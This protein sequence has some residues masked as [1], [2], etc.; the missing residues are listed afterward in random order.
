[1]IPE[2][3]YARLFY[4]GAAWLVL[5]VVLVVWT[6]V[7]TISGHNENSRASEQRVAAAKVEHFYLVVAGERSGSEPGP[8]NKL[9]RDLRDLHIPVGSSYVREVQAFRGDSNRYGGVTRDL[10]FDPFEGPNCQE[11]GP[12]DFSVQDTVIAVKGG[13]IDAVIAEIESGIV[14]EDPISAPPLLLWFLWILSFPSFVA[15]TYIH[16]KRREES[17]YRD[18]SHERG[19]IADLKEARAQL[20]A[21]AERD[22]IDILIDGLQSQIDTRVNYAQVKKRD[23]RL[24]ALVTDAT[25]ALGGIEAGNRELR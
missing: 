8:G 5:L 1:M 16:T 12:L 18:F 6:L 22:R 17:R 4:Y 19:L 7:A 23:M 11:C 3:T 2:K 15:V 10:G 25:E 14:E 9:A 20:P 24:D 21:S 13:G